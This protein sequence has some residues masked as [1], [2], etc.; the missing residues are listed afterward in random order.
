MVVASDNADPEYFGGTEP[1][2]G[3]EIYKSNGDLAWHSG[4]RQAI[5]NNVIPANQFTTGTNQN[6]NYDVTTGYD[7][8]TAP[9]ILD[10]VTPYGMESTGQS[11]SLTSLNE[12]DPSKNLLS[13]PCC[14][15]LCSLLY[16]NMGRFR[17]RYEW[18]SR[19]RAA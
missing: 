6:G 13:W 8:V 1:D 15:R 18:L 17:R 4:W 11:V 7:G 9:V 14:N 19:W 2:Y 3:V 5:L 10:N 16:G 12:M